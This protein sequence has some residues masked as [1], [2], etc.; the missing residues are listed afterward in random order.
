MK[1]GKNVYVGK[2]FKKKMIKNRYAFNRYGI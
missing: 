2:Q 1:N